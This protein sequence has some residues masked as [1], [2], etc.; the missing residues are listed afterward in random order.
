M[1]HPQAQ[2]TLEIQ[3]RKDEKDIGKKQHKMEASILAN[4]SANHIC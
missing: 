2:S 1:A 4:R 3:D